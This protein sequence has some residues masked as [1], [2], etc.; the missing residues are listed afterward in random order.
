MP[1]INKKGFNKNNIIFIHALNFNN[2]LIK[3]F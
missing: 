2:H 3:Y 1:G